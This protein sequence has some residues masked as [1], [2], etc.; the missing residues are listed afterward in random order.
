MKSF[1]QIVGWL[2]RLIS[3]F[4][5]ITSLDSNILKKLKWKPA[6]K[7]TKITVIFVP[8]LS[9][10]IVI[11][12]V[13]ENRPLGPSAKSLRHLLHD[14]DKQ[15]ELIRIQTTAEDYPHE[16]WLDF[17]VKNAEYQ[18]RR[19]AKLAGLHNFRNFDKEKM[20]PDPASQKAIQE[21]ITRKAKKRPPCIMQADGALRRG[22]NPRYSQNKIGWSDDPDDYRPIP[23]IEPGNPS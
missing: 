6:P 1:D 21:Q 19:D 14:A 18:D 2:W 4:A 5:H 3:F 9:R 23:I 10:Q 13:P 11:R 12:K 15:L 20:K 7:L 22:V 16:T 8:N 17:N